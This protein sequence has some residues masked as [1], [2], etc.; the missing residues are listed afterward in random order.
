[1][2]FR[3]M[4]VA[5]RNGALSETAAGENPIDLFMAWIG[6]ARESGAILEPNAMTLATVGADGAPAARMVLLKEVGDDGSFVFYT[7]RMGRKG[8]EIAANPRVALVF[9]WE[10]LERQVRIE[11][12]IVETSAEETAAYFAVRPRE[13]RIGAWASN[14]SEPIASRDDL[15]KQ[16][17]AADAAHPGEDVPVPPWWGG[18]SVQPTAIEFWQGRMGRMHDRLSY[19]RE[20]RHWSRTRLQP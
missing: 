11:G 16:F 4:R 8:L 17:A 1:M 20:G 14:Q 7:N 10:P 6:T 12:A 19:S 5:Y 18:Y 13:S 15:E 3:E 2:A 9:W